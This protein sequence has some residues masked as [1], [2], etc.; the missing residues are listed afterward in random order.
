MIHEL[1]VHM[2]HSRDLLKRRFDPVRSRVV[3]EI[4]KLSSDSIAAGL[5]TI[6]CSEE[7]EY[8]VVSKLTG[9]SNHCTGE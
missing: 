4:H 9:Q 8:N 2:N 6:L 1:N 5:G 7:I 3:P